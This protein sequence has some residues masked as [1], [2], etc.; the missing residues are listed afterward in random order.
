MK[1]V[2]L[3]TLLLVGALFTSFGALAWT[4]P[5]GLPT[6]SNIQ[7]PIHTG[8]TAQTKNGSL[9]LGGLAVFGNTRVQQNR[10]INW[11][12]TIGEPGY[13]LRSNAGTMEY[14][15]E[16]DPAWTP[17]GSGSGSGSQ[18]YGFTGTGESEWPQWEICAQTSLSNVICETYSATNGWNNEVLT[19]TSQSMWYKEIPGQ[20]SSAWKLCSLNGYTTPYDH[21]TV[22]Y[23]VKKT[24]QKWY[25]Y[26]S[27]SSSGIRAPNTTVNCWR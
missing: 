6:T 27:R 25:L 13:G 26:A 3:P 20:S 18:Q 4:N 21:G 23:V 15:N 16:G 14:K 2:F 1:T 12:T 9:G 24:D 11:G 19:G 10:Y 7:S 22:T 5:S 17:F 8:S